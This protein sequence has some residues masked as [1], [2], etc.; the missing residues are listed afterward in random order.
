MYNN[1][2][3]MGSDSSAGEIGHVSIDFKGRFCSCG[4]RGYLEQYINT[5]AII[6]PQEN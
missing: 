6:K 1:Q 5:D 2:V 3:M 4:N